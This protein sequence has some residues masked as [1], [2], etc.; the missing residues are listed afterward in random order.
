MEHLVVAAF[1]FFQADRTAFWTSL[2]LLITLMSWRA[3]QL[4]LE[5]DITRIFPNDDRVRKVSDVLTNTRFADR[6]VV[7]VSV[8]DSATA[9]VP[10]SLTRCAGEVSV[11]AQNGRPRVPGPGPRP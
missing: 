11:C 9:P 5:E 3:T 6:L 7:M 2:V 4:N 8:R 1:R 10:D